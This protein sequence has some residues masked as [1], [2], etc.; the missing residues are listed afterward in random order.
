MGMWGI[1]EFFVILP[2]R[3]SGQSHWFADLFSLLHIITTTKGFVPTDH[4]KRRKQSSDQWSIFSAEIQKHGRNRLNSCI[5]AIMIL[6]HYPRRGWTECIS[7]HALAHP[8]PAGLTS[9]ANTEEQNFWKNHQWKPKLLVP[10]K[11]LIFW[12]ALVRQP[13]RGVGVQRCS[14]DLL[15]MSPQSRSK[16]NTPPSL[17]SMLEIGA[18]TSGTEMLVFWEGY[19]KHLGMFWD[20]CGHVEPGEVSCRDMSELTDPWG[21]PVM[22]PWGK[23]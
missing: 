4:Q 23:M 3:C 1:S 13:Q 12:M 10:I 2:G 15:F 6:L 22:S 19:G 7:S 16:D 11:C 8:Q 14:H 18:W 20:H 5:C 17:P 9:H 21:F